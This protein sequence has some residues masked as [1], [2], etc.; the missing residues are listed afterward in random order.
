VL[1]GDPFPFPSAP[2]LLFAILSAIRLY[3][4]FTRA[5]PK[6]LLDALLYVIVL[7]L[8][9]SNLMPKPE[10]EVTLLFVILQRSTVLK[11]IPAFQLRLNS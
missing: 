11:Y 9:L 4:A 3:D 7:W 2:V 8:E 1:G 5:I 10:C 6:L